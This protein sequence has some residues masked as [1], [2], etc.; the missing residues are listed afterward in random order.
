VFEASKS[1]RGLGRR[2]GRVGAHRRGGGRPRAGKH[3]VGHAVHGA[4]GE[5]GQAQRRKCSDVVL[6]RLQDATCCSLHDA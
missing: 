1:P 6:L 4:E 2:G 3:D 5:E